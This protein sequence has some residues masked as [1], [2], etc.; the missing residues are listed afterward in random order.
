MLEELKEFRRTVYGDPEEK[1][2]SARTSA[3]TGVLIFVGV[4]LLIGGLFT[5]TNATLGVGLIGIAIFLSVLARLAQA[6]TQ[7]RELIENLRK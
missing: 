3:A 7:Q 4:L 6:R 2:A 1:P 5:L